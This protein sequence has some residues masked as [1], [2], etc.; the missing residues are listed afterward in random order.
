M[1][2]QYAERYVRLFLHT[3][4]KEFDLSHFNK[5]NFKV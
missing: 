5:F 3:G 4:V 2:E 1:E